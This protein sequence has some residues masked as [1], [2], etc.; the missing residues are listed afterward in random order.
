M[1]VATAT[2]ETKGRAHGFD[3]AGRGPPLILLHGGQ[4]DRREWRRNLADLAADF[5]VI[6]WDAPGCGLSDDAPE[7]ASL[8]DYA[9][10]L[11]EF[12][13]AVG[14]APAAVAGLSF[15]GGLAIELQHRHPDTV[16]ALVL[17]SAYAGWAG[18]LEPAEIAARLEGLAHM[19]PGEVLPGLFATD[20][21][22]AVEAL[23]AE[24]AADVRPRTLRTM[25]GAFAVADLR[26][27]LPGID[28]PTLVLH[29]DADARSPPHVARAL[30]AAIPGAKLVTL[31][32]HGHVLNLE[33][34]ERFAREV[35]EF[36]LG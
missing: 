6:A 35:R 23:N 14:V 22:P 27:A 24:I 31:P 18:S 3:R 11:A 36:L 29:G 4:S 16:S 26:P 17:V 12:I 25:V 33:A 10:A 15:G 5:T 2:L 34:P 7:D 9:D 32:G 21:D 19:Q 1:D 8:A 20:V 28:V 13:R 30:H